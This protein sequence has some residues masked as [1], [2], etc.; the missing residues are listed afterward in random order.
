MCHLVLLL[1]VIA[2]PLFW[3]LPLSVAGPLYGAAAAL[4]GVV[5][6]Y[7]WDTGRRPVRIGRECMQGA[8]GE[9]L[10]TKPS[11]RVRVYG[12][13]WQA[14]CADDLSPGDT[15]RVEDLDHLTL[16]VSKAAASAWEM[17]KA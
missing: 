13:I 3:L 17:V 9:V 5:Y 16:Q 2:L 14:R 4:A 12:E 15:V 11:L 10:T 8:L 6:Y 7:A 1:P